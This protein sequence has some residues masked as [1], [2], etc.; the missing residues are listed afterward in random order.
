MKIS[1]WEDFS[2]L[3]SSCHELMD[4]PEV[5]V[6]KTLR[7]VLNRGC[8]CNKE[9]KKAQ[10]EEVYCNIIKKYRNDD[11]FKQIMS[12]HIQLIGENKISFLSNNEL[13]TSIPN[14]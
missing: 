4:A 14:E 12:E 1:G 7:S 3:I 8:R 11:G 5:A 6:F 2:E 9:K 10:L 13:I